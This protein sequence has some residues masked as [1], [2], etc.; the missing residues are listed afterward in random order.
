MFVD[1]QCILI[2][3]I[4]SEINLFLLLFFGHFCL[5]VCFS[6]DDQLSWFF[7]ACRVW[8]TFQG[9]GSFSDKPGKVWANRDKLVTLV[10]QVNH[11]VTRGTVLE[12]GVLSSVAIMR[13]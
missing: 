11:V 12:T 3:S 1:L 13:L 5:F 6:Q 9:H 10:I 7:W 2:L 4:V 8:Q